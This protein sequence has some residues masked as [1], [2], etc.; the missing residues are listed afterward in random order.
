[1]NYYLEH[2]KDN[3]LRNLMEIKYTIKY[4]WV[5]I[6]SSSVDYDIYQIDVKTCKKLGYENQNKGG[7]ISVCLKYIKEELRKEKL[8]RIVNELI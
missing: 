8:K 1:M 7:F 2:H 6:Q 4:G 3:S 5:R